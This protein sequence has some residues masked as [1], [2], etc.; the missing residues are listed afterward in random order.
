MSTITVA[1]GTSTPTSITVVATSTS[2]SPAA[3][4]RI[5][6]SFSSA[7]IRP[8][9]TIDAQVAERSLDER[10]GDV[11]DGQR[12]PPRLVARRRR[13]APPS[14]TPARRRSAGTP[15]RPGGRRPPPRGPAASPAPARPAA[16]AGT[17]VVWIGDAAGGQLAQGRDV[18]VAEHRHRD[19]SR[20]RRRGHD[21]HMRRC[22]A[23]LG[24]SARPAARRRTGA[25]RRRRPGRG[26][27]TCTLSSSSAWVP[28]TIPAAP[29]AMSSRAAGARRGRH[30]AGQQRDPGAPSSPRRASRPRPA[31]RAWPRS[32][33]GA[34]GEHLGRREQGRL[35]TGVDDLEHRAQRHDGLARA[36]LALQQ[37]LHR[38][39]R[40]SS[41][42]MTSPIS[43]WPAVSSNGSLASNLAARPPRGAAAGSAVERS[44]PASGAGP[45]RSAGR[46]PRRT[47]AGR[48]P[49]AKSAGP[50]GWWISAQGLVVAGQAAAHV[51]RR[52]AAGP[53]PGRAPPAPSPTQA[54]SVRDGD[55]GD[56][57]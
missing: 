13:P 53:G 41:A 42:A 34:G 46:T 45:A 11:G 57:G 50:A 2:M 15:R 35:A 54:V 8:C 27:R 6:S 18:E 17:T 36:D 52:Q 20:D 28:T 7:G 56:A 40:P 48:A 33:G 4:R 30:R 23:G 31:G 43:C 16:P 22:E 49:A 26:R 1:L 12:R 44:A 47:A 51:V 19:R 25:A 55:A 39:S 21:Q 38:V 32:P 29:D 5:T 14:R 10:G 3:N 9:S 37:P 24:A